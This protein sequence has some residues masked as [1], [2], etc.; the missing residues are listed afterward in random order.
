MKKERLPR[1]PIKIEPADLDRLVLQIVNPIA[2]K[3]L[4]ETQHVATTRSAM[5]I[6]ETIERPIVVAG[7]EDFVGMRL[8]AHPQAK[9]VDFGSRAMIADVSCVQQQVPVGHTE[10]SV[11]SVGIRDADDLHSSV[12]PNS[13]APFLKSAITEWAR[14]LL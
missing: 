13:A 7:D 14:L 10:L 9:R 6:R 11:V 4:G 1:S 3:L 12:F 2:L 8:F 5:V